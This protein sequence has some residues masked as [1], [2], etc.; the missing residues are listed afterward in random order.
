VAGISR[1]RFLTRGLAAAAS[2]F[3]FGGWLFR[4]RGRA[5]GSAATPP[6]PQRAGVN[7]AA[8]VGANPAAEFVG[9]DPN[10]RAQVQTINLGTGKAVGAPFTVPLEGFPN[11]WVQQP[12]DV[13]TVMALGDATEPEAWP[14]AP[15]FQ[16]DA[17]QLQELVASPG[18]IQN[19]NGMPAV[20]QKSTVVHDESFSGSTVHYWA[21]PNARGSPSQVI[22]VRGA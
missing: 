3:I 1:R 19:L 12:G 18:A 20:A 8:S 14:F 15:V 10:G 22:A 11:G 6:V 21:V 4:G 16:T 13:L 9:L 17:A 2:G 5:P 7:H